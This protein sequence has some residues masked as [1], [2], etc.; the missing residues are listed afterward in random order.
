MHHIAREDKFQVKFSIL[1]KIMLH[2]TLLVFAAVA[3]STYLAVKMEYKTLKAGII[4]NGKNM[5]KHIAS[6]TES[7]FWSLNW[8]FAEKL[9]QQTEQKS[10]GEVIFAKIV[11]PDGEVYLAN[12]RAYYGSSI[13]P[14]LLFDQETILENHYFADKKEYGMLLVHPI[15]IGKDTWYV[16]LGL[17]L[18]PIKAVS[19]K[20]VLHNVIWGGLVLLMAA[21]VSFFLSRSISKPLITLSKATEDVADGNWRYIES[22]GSNDEVGL[23]SYSFNRMIKGLENAKGALNES[24]ETL[25]TVLDSIYA[26]I[27]VAD[28]ATYEILFMNKNMQDSFGQNFVGEICWKAFRNESSPCSHCTNKKLLDEQG[29]PMEVIIWECQNPIT[30]KW[31]INYDRAIMWRDGRLVR[32][33]I[34]TDVT[35]R[36][37]AEQNLKNAHAK[38]EQRVEERTAELALTNQ[39]FKEEIEERKRAE[40]IAESANRAKSE[41]LANMSHEIRTPMNAI[42][43]M[44]ELASADTALSRK[45]HDY[46][47]IIRSSSRSLLGI[48]NDILDFSKIEAGKLQIE[49]APLSLRELI[50]EVFD[51]FQEKIQEKQLECMVDIAPEVPRKVVTDPLRLR[52][53]LVN[54][55]S[56][57]LKFTDSGEICLAVENKTLTPDRVELLFSVR[58]SG[59]GIDPQIQDTLFNAFAQADGSTTRKYGGTGLGLAIS[60]KIISLMGGHIW[61]ESRPGVGSTF[62]FTTKFRYLPA[63]DGRGCLAPA[64]LKN[65]KVLIVED[66]AS[67]ARIIRRFIE[68]FGFRA[69]T[70]PSAEQ[71]LA[72]YKDCINKAPFDLILMDILLPD[73]DGIAAAQ[74]IK[75]D[76]PV[77]APPIIIVSA[78]GRDEALQRAT[79]IGIESY[80]SKPVRPSLL[81]DTIME[82]FGHQTSGLGYVGT[83][84]AD[85]ETFSGAHILLVEDNETNQM[86]AVEILENTGICVDIAENGLEAIAAI[87]KRRYDAVLMDVQMPQMDGIEATRVIRG[88]LEMTDLPIIAMTANAM[89]GDRE[90]YLAAGMNGYVPKPIDQT[91]LFAALREHISP[92]KRPSRPQDKSPDPEPAAE[93][94]PLGVLPGLDMDEGVRR[95]GGRRDRY[96]AI[97]QKFCR[98][99]ENF[100]HEYGVLVQNGDFEAARNKAHALKGA[101][102]NLSAIEL[103]EAARALEEAGSRKNTS[104]MLRCL[105]TVEQALEQVFASVEKIEQTDT[106]SVSEDPARGRGERSKFG[107]LLARFKRSLQKFDLMES[108]SCLEELKSNITTVDCRS[109]LEN[110]EAQ[111]LAY[112]FVAAQKA[113]KPLS[114]KLDV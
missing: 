1:H 79:D 24:N 105:T 37:M 13:N 77:K 111:I 21:F 112:D 74:K 93:T 55:L 90:K 87:K 15:L 91:E 94:R 43:N 19:E 68:S 46:L 44:S 62:L 49:E 7:A 69:E 114:E 71:A 36:K 39:Q 86:V 63:E 113:L 41:F 14:E 60:K 107:A 9:L 64:G 50:E 23:L 22:A 70:A 45:Q 6:S 4:H 52:Q 48:I 83:C 85:P 32:I 28:M 10:R 95:L 102:G 34:A 20:L 11:K 72:L 17:S 57:A 92:S 108:E 42:I 89:S 53:V 29:N 96:V 66:N 40:D 38:L 110:L 56:N 78:L 98:A 35:D 106:A 100:S 81:F 59:I 103:N 97:L 16:V 18:Q 8:I 73:M 75:K 82:V 67:T 26:D 104:Q 5:A 3:T 47:N 31:Y 76:Y 99:Q 54:L 2:V 65:L 61:V 30:K 58:D 88:Q 80:L 27:Y 109:E 25:L 51:M 84:F 33:Q 12:D 101:A